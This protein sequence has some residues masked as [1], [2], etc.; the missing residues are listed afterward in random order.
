MKLSDTRLV[1]IIM[2]VYNAENFLKRSIESILNQKYYNFELIIVDDG[3]TDNSY[4]ISKDYSSMDTRILVKSFDNSGPATARNRGLDLAKGEYLLFVDSDDY[5]NS[6]TIST[7]VDEIESSKVDLVCAGHSDDYGDTKKNVSPEGFYGSFK[8]ALYDF[9][10][11]LSRHTLQGPWA[12]IFRTKIIQE[13]K[14]AFPENMVFGEDTMFVYKYIQH[15]HNVKIIENI[16]YNHSIYDGSLSRR[17]VNNI[18]EIYIN[19]YSELQKTLEKHETSD[20]HTKLAERYVSSI[21]HALTTIFFVDY[22]TK[23]SEKRRQLNLL[24][25]S[26]ASKA[27]IGKVKGKGIQSHL[28]T[29]SIKNGKVLILTLF[30]SFKEQLRNIKDTFRR[31]ESNG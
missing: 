19:L 1:S 23:T 14:L 10:I 17:S 3:S 11:L 22:N 2:P 29:R 6:N 27:L 31:R 12:K 5:I 15:S 16:L 8:D 4:Q 9:D 21:K 28:I 30:Y 18:I 26:D 13:N 7:L 20:Y 24:V 25:S